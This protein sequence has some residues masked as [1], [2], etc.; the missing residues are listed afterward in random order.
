MVFQSD[1]LHFAAAKQE[2]PGSQ[3]CPRL[4]ISALTCKGLHPCSSRRSTRVTAA[5]HARPTR[6]TR[7][8][9]PTDAYCTLSHGPAARSAKPTR[10]RPS[11]RPERRSAEPAATG[12]RSRS[13]RLRGSRRPLAEALGQHDRPVAR[14]SSFLV[15]K[16]VIV[17]VVGGRQGL[18]LACAFF[19]LVNG[20]ME[21]MTIRLAVSTVAPARENALVCQIFSLMNDSV[22]PWDQ[23]SGAGLRCLDRW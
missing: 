18:L 23:C 19:W 13:G 12:L 22:S 15:V 7:S 20:T 9:K 4:T 5:P 14:A 16:I 1:F 10:A 2:C 3:R 6:P 21:W 8:A 11:P 17:A